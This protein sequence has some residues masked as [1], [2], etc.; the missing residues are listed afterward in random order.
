MGLDV[1]SVRCHRHNTSHL[2]GTLC[3]LC[4]RERGARHTEERLERERELE[5]ERAAAV[6]RH[7]PLCGCPTC[8]RPALC[9]HGRPREECESLPPVLQLA[10]GAELEPQHVRE[11]RER[12]A[13]IAACLSPAVLEHFGTLLQELHTL[14]AAKTGNLH[15]WPIPRTFLAPGASCAIQVNVYEPCRLIRFDVTADEGARALELTRVGRINVGTRTIGEGGSLAQLN[16]CAC[17]RLTLTPSV[18]ASLYVEN[19]SASGITIGGVVLSEALRDTG[20]RV[21]MLGRGIRYNTEGPTELARRDSLSAMLAT[22]D[23]DEEAPDA[24]DDDD[25]DAGFYD[26]D[27]G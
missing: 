15:R 9:I 23:P 16:G 10:P 5:R 20:G 2:G 6:Q 1:L 13:A 26:D 3:P 19:L 27:D 8:E 21:P 17:A 11:A 24:Y 18:G 22:L 25:D 12:A 7:G 4:E 14:H